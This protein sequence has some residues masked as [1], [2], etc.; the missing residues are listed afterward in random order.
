MTSR[1]GRHSAPR[2]GL[3][4]CNPGGF[5]VSGSTR[6]VDRPDT[7]PE[8]SW[9]ASLAATT[10]AEVIALPVAFAEREG[11]DFGFDLVAGA[12]VVGP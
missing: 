4:T 7:S 3:R 8:P 5:A 9:L 11:A 12:A 6:T 2:P 10:G 1:M